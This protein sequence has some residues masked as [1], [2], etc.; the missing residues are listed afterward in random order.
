MSSI[1]RVLSGWAIKFGEAE[2]TV[3]ERLV[4]PEGFRIAAKATRVHGVTQELAVAGSSLRCVLSEFMQDLSEASSGGGRVVCHHAE[5][6]CGILF[7][8]LVR[9]GMTDV[10]PRW[11]TL[12]RAGVCTMDPD[13]GRWVR[14]TFNEEV[15]TAYQKHA[16]P[17][18]ELVS[19]LLPNRADLMKRH[20]SAGESAAT[21]LNVWAALR[22]LAAPQKD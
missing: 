10:V 18:K 12:V 19:R 3:K 11:A 2:I 15:G 17:L 20:R 13:I 14:E 6:H 4:T 5:F 16:L 1:R 8:E 7:S 21:V 9:C 22:D